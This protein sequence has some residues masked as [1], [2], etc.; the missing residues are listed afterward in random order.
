M[1]VNLLQRALFHSLIAHCRAQ[2]VGGYSADLVSAFHREAT[3]VDISR[4][5]LRA[6]PM[7][8]GNLVD[9]TSLMAHSNKLNRLPLAFGTI[10]SLTEIDL[11]RNR[12]KALP[13]TFSRL[14]N[15]R[16]LRLFDN[17]IEI[18]DEN[19]TKLGTLQRLDLSRN[20]IKVLPD[21]HV[22]ILQSTFVQCPHCTAQ[23]WTGILIDITA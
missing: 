23:L 18:F 17:R 6:V 16:T 14:A 21:K 1:P 11:S 20:S 22:K 8:V 13:Q 15:L 3:F 7:S 5:G 12:L 19:W 9:C 10:E 4:R 2:Y